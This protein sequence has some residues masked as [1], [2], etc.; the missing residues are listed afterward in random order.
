MVITVSERNYV[1]IMSTDFIQCVLKIIIKLDLES[2]H[3]LCVR[4][5][6]VLLKACSKNKQALRIVRT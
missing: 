6:S 4:G 5:F 1:K 3:H 2:K